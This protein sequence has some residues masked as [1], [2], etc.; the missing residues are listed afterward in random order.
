MPPTRKQRK[1]LKQYL[2]RV[3]NFVGPA[4]DF[5]ELGNDALAFWE[6]YFWGRVACHLHMRVGKRGQRGTRNLCADFKVFRCM[7]EIEFETINGTFFELKPASR[8]KYGGYHPVFISV[9]EDSEDGKR[10]A[11]RLA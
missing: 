7:P 5:I 9:G 8:Y 3:D 6:A 2:E 4:V 11:L 1:Q 10:V